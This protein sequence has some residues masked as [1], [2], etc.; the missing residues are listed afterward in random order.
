MSDH[1]GVVKTAGGP[2]ASAVGSAVGVGSKDGGSETML[3]GSDTILSGSETM[4]DGPGTM[5]DNDGGG[6]GNLA[7]VRKVGHGGF[8]AVWEARWRGAPAAVKVLV[9]SASMT[10]EARHERMAL[11]EVRRG[12]DWGASTP[13]FLFFKRILGLC[14]NF[15]CKYFLRRP[16]ALSTPQHG[17][18]CG[19]T[20][21]PL[22]LPFPASLHPLLRRPRLTHWHTSTIQHAPPLSTL[23]SDGRDR[24]TGTPEHRDHLQVPHT[25]TALRQPASPILHAPL[26]LD[27]SRSPYLRATIS[28]QWR[29]QGEGS[30]QGQQPRQVLW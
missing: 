13:M 25:P 5:I 6:D 29:R 30:R 17:A 23:C 24:R 20:P 19:H 8:G 7:L 4:L 2:S 3:G 16:A 10:R 28:R 18:L 27:G 1:H 21:T 12:D 22:P 9:F 14:L 26:F 15:L 11:M